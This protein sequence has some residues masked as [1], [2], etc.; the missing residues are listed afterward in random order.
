MPDT[1]SGTGIIVEFSKRSQ[2]LKGD[3]SMATEITIKITV[4][5][6]A[7]ALSQPT[8]TVSKKT[9]PVPRMSDVPAAPQIGQ[10]LDKFFGA[11]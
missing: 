9:V 7:A 2:A 4:G 6:E 8:V 11:G 5:G 3:Q 10:Y 1:A